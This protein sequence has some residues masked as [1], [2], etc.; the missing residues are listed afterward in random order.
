M[1]LTLNPRTEARLLAEADRRGV[2]PDAVIDALLTEGEVSS[3]SPA[4]SPDAEEK[5]QERLRNA[6]A[7]LRQEALTLVPDPPDSPTRVAAHESA[8]GEAIVE[9]FRRQGFNL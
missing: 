9:K 2:L 1:T 7:Q 3:S 6:L 8:F 4:L 5:E